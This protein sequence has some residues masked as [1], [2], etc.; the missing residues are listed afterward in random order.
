MVAK[1]IPAK[2]SSKKPAILGN[3]ERMTAEAATKS[4]IEADSAKLI[5]GR[6]TDSLSR[7]WSRTEIEASLKD[8]MP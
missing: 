4:L 7:D 1:Q 3:V 5:V 6:L 8:L 2:T